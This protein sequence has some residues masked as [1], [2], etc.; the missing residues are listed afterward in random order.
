MH[1][2][3]LLIHEVHESIFQLP[4][5]QYIL[6]FDDGLYSQYYYYERFKNIPTQKYYFISTNILCNGVQSNNF[7]A[8]TVA[9]SKAEQCNYE[10]YMTLEQIKTLMSDP[11]V[12]IGGHGHNHIDLRDLTLG[13]SIDVIKYDTSQMLHWFESN[14]DYTPTTFAFPYN[15]DMKSIYRAYLASV[16]FTKFYGSERIVVEDLL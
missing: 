5:E 2:P 15:Y 7:P 4:L 13:Q 1:K 8:C 12:T 9:H 10:D 3:V 11:L 6:T 14:L 16:G